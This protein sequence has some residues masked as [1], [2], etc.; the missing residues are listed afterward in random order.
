MTN[1]GDTRL[2]KESRQIIQKPH[3]LSLPEHRILFPAKGR[4]SGGGVPG[5][6]QVGGE[7]VEEAGA[8][9]LAGVDRL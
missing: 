2:P 5:G 7:G 3:D 8:A 1:Q 6:G 4:G 9:G